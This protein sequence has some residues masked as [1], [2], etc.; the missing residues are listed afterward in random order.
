LIPGTS[1]ETVETQPKHPHPHSKDCRPASPTTACGY[2]A[3]MMT[4][5]MN[6][7]ES[8]QAKD[9]SEDMLETLM[10]INASLTVG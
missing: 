7:V 9:L 6:V 1:D 2:P 10:A 8:I 3:M 5:F 4:R